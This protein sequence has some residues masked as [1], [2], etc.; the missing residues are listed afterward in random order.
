[1][2]TKGKLRCFPSTEWWNERGESDERRPGGWKDFTHSANLQGA[3]PQCMQP[4]LAHVIVLHHLSTFTVHKLTPLPLTPRPSHKPFP[5]LSPS[6]KGAPPRSPT[7]GSLARRKLCPPLLRFSH[8]SQLAA[9][10]CEN[11][12]SEL[13]TETGAPKRRTRGTPHSRSKWGTE[14]IVAVHRCSRMGTYTML[15]KV[16]GRERRRDR[17]A[18]LL[19]PDRSRACFRR[20]TRACGRGCHGSPKVSA[21]RQGRRSGELS[22][23]R[24]K[25]RITGQIKAI[26]TRVTLRQ[27]RNLARPVEA[28]TSAAASL[29][30][31][32]KPPPI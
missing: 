15:R 4:N 28:R 7:A 19:T 10:A 14:L 22:H 1:M 12:H 20:Q 5:P 18:A 23:S 8:T 27:L 21:H 11:A 2:I 32:L 30:S 3:D 25:I 6:Q 29:G 16:R 13:I 9:R 26:E 24:L 31:R 17:D